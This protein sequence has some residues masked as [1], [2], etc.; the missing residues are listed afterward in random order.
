MY[1]ASMF[2]SV[3]SMQTGKLMSGTQHFFR[4]DIRNIE[5]VKGAEDK[6]RYIYSQSSS[7]LKVISVMCQ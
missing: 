2:L 6:L 1:F 3:R 7:K 5:I 4:G